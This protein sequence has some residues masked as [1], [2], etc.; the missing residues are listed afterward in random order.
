MNQRDMYQWIDVCRANSDDLQQDELQALAELVERDPRAAELLARSQRLDEAFREALS[1][2]PV[3][4]SLEQRLLAAVAGSAVAQEALTL[5]KPEADH[6]GELDRP[7]E[8]RPH[9][10]P[11]PAARPLET[12]GR[13]RR[14]WLTLVGAATAAGLLLA[15]GWW[16]GASG[17]ALSE[18][19]LVQQAQGWSKR[20]YADDFVWRS[21]REE[22]PPQDRPLSPAVFRA[23]GRWSQ[24]PAL[25]DSR[26]VVFELHSRDGVPGLVFVVRT[27]RDSGLAPLPYR[28]LSAAGVSSGWTIAA[29]QTGELLYVV[30]V[31]G[32]GRSIDGFVRSAP[33]V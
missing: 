26:A 17:G 25:D 6:L 4:E 33:A 7:E 22:V 30:V 9:G 21:V 28:Q 14:H 3:P 8:H 27:R 32:E 29:W 13:S 12:R 18:E 2:V 19:A 31:P 24:L 5:D 11:T 23:T 20:A 10:Y 1:D 16:F 15:A